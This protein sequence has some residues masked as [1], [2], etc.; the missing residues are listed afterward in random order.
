MTET[1][2]D[3]FLG[4][5]L[6]IRQPAN[7][8]RAGHDSVLVAAAVPAKAGE[9]VLELGSGAG[10]TSL[11]L[12]ARVAGVD[13]MGVEI[14]PDLAALANA[15]AA[16]NG[17]ESR[18]R[19][20]AGEVESLG[21]DVFDHVFF[22]PP[23]HRDTGQMSPSPERDRARRDVADAVPRWT[24]IALA[25][26]KPG[27][28]VTAIVSAEREGD[29]VSAAYGNAVTVLPFL[30]REGDAPKRV[31]VQ[32]RKGVRGPLRRLSGFALHSPGGGNTERAETVLRHAAALDL[33]GQ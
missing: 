10:V 13:I 3:G 32:I 5:R 21:S 14:D 30:P 15:N 11:C 24:E 2:A 33:D 6:L 23:F 26:A 27:G 17:M 8:F 18:V 1:T 4:G 19:F 29:I 16:A 22:N 12:A 25:H 31:I 9:R 20:A 7:G 28:T